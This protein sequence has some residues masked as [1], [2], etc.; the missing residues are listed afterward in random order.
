MS[1][2]PIRNAFHEWTSHKDEFSAGWRGG[3]DWKKPLNPSS[4]LLIVDLVETEKDYQIIAD[5]PGVAPENLEVNLHENVVNIKADKKNTYNEEVDK[6]HLVERYC[7]ITTRD[8][9]LPKNADIEHNNITFK[10][11]VLR[12]VFPK[13]AGQPPIEQKKLSITHE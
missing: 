11:G 4:N 10:N 7:G 1:F 12:I 13:L 8:I 9:Q 3:G 6:L 5:A 2:G